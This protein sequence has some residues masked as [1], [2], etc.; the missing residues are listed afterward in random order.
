[1]GVPAAE[2]AIPIGWKA[3]A[4]QGRLEESI[5]RHANVDKITH[6]L[7]SDDHGSELIRFISWMA[8]YI[9]EVTWL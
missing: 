2:F 1:M 6:A 9:L 4:E 5:L 8:G 7:V 3:A